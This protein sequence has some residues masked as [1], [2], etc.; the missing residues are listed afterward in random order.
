[1]RRLIGAF[2]LLLPLVASA[3]DYCVIPTL[4]RGVPVTVSVPQIGK[5]LCGM[6]LIDNRYVKIDDAAIR[7]LFG[8]VRCNEDGSDCRQ[9]ADYYLSV[10]DSEHFIVIYRGP[11]AAN[12]G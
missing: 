11:K 5:H 7:K 8:P 2:A 10:Q 3:G 1:M 12:P 9:R 6:A 4:Y